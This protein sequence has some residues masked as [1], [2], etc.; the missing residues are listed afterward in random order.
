MHI[1][2]KLGFYGLFF[3]LP[4]I[5][6]LKGKGILVSLFVAFFLFD[7]PQA[8]VSMIKRPLSL[9]KW[10]LSP[11]LKVGILCT[12]ALFCVYVRNWESMFTL[13][14]L[15][16]LALIVAATSLGIQTQSADTRHHVTK[17]FLGGG[18]FYIGFFLWEIYGP[19]WAS[20]CIT[21]NTGFNVALFIRGTV[22]LTF[23]AITMLIAVDRFDSP[24]KHL[25]IYLFSSA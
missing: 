8:C 12:V 13:L 17:V 14:R 21:D 1:I 24:K 23:L 9:K 5:A 18:L 4:L 6:T 3:S 16:G 7:G 19:A 11:S 2:K 22:I 10:I 15:V 25:H 20:K